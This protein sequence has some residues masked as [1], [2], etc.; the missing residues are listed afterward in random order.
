[1]I[2]SVII[3]CGCQAKY[4][5][6]ASTPSCA[7]ATSY[8]ASSTKHCRTASATYTS[9]STTKMRAF[10]PPRADDEVVRNGASSSESS[11]NSLCRTRKYR[12]SRPISKGLYSN[13]TASIC[14]SVRR[15]TERLLN[16]ITRRTRGH[17]PLPSSS[18]REGVSLPPKRAEIRKASSR[19]YKSTSASSSS[20]TL[21]SPFPVSIAIVEG[22]NTA[23]YPQQ[24]TLAAS[25]WPKL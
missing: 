1:M 17:C 12:C 19:S 3:Q 23:S 6:K 21:L 13:A 15:D 5:S 22:S 7:S 16:A 25:I 24:R 14:S 2:R 20:P 18:R 11:K 4:C 10:V 9:S 8:P